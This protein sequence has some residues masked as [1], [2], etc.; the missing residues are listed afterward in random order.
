MTNLILNQKIGFEQIL[1]SLKKN[2]KI[3]NIQ[4]RRHSKGGRSDGKIISPRKGDFI[5]RIYRFI[6]FKRNIIL[7]QKA[8]YLRTIYDPNRT[9][10][11]GLLCYPMGIISYILKPAKI[12]NGEMIGNIENPKDPIFYGDASKIANFN[13]GVLIYNINGKFIRSAGASAILVRKD[14]EQALLKMKSGELRYFNQEM[15]ATSGTVNNENH[16]LR[17][18][19]KAGTMRLLGKRPRTRPLL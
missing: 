6:D 14:A 9:A 13:S 11:I 19:K 3:K 18:Y 12:E 7:H 4:I 17:N 10:S 15:M 2:E 1:N 16:F 8:I 5:K